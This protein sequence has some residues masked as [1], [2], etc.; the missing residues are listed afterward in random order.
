LFII[1]NGEERKKEEEKKKESG[2]NPPDVF[3]GVALGHVRGSF[4]IRGF[5][6]P[7]GNRNGDE[8]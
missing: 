3:S 1:G 5:N 8:S 7:K 4:R 2:T 6:A